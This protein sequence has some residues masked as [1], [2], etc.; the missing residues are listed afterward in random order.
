MNKSDI[1]YIGVLLISLGIVIFGLVSMDVKPINALGKKTPCE[2]V[3]ECM[4]DF[5]D[6]GTFNYFT[7]VSH[8]RWSIESRSCESV[9]NT[10]KAVCCRE[11]SE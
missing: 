9:N 4:Q 3:V 11:I 7:W 10:I 1:L 5:Q 2:C 6:F 8:K